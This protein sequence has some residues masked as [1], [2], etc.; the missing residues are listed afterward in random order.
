MHNSILHHHFSFKTLNKYNYSFLVW[1][2]NKVT[3][4]TKTEI[5][6]KAKDQP[7][8]DNLCELICSRVKTDELFWVPTLPSMF[9]QKHKMRYLTHSAKLGRLCQ[10]NQV[11]F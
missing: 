5:V 11:S 9:S 10:H 2:M 1:G 3:I 8:Y 6:M 4:I 7:E